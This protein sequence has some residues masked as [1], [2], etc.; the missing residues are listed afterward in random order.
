MQVSL[1]NTSDYEKICY[2]KGSGNAWKIAPH[3][4][5]ELP[6]GIADQML[7]E[8]GRWVTKWHPSAIPERPGE[9]K[10]W[11]ANVSGNPFQPTTITKP[12]K[13]PMDAPIEVPN[14]KL[15][16]EVLQFDWNPGQII[17]RDATNGDIA[18]SPVSETIKLLP[19][20]RYYV[21]LSIA[22]MITQR[23]GL[24]P[25]ER[26]GRVQRC[27]PPADFEPSTQWSIQD[28]YIYA[29]MLDAAYFNKDT[30]RTRFHAEENLSGKLSQLEEVKLDL[31][32]YIK[33][34]LLDDQFN[35]PTREGFEKRKNEMVAAVA[36]KPS[37]K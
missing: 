23:D 27:R 37:S 16:P 9:E 8:N 20:E 21:P 13:D 31:L 35:P 5:R 1:Q 14:P 6:Q 2:E 3:Q 15:V 12:A 32:H 28:L 18:L 4:V 33:Y 25:T 22:S 10:V 17:I 34:R 26:A 11:I 30:L 36:A 7:E 29:N 19:G 24:Q